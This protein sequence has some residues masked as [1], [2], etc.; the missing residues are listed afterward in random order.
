ME[1]VPS[2]RNYSR[3]FT[4]KLMAK[5]LD[6]AMASA[7]G[8]G[9]KC[10]MGSNALEIYRKL[11]EDGCELKDFS[12]A[13]QHYY[14]RKNEEWSWSYAAKFPPFEI[15]K[16]TNKVRTCLYPMNWNQYLESVFPCFII[17]LLSNWSKF[18]EPNMSL[19]ESLQYKL[20]SIVPETWWL[21]VDQWWWS[22][23]LFKTVIGLLLGNRVILFWDRFNHEPR[24]Y[25]HYDGGY[26]WGSTRVPVVLPM[27]E[28]E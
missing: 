8:V 18:L 24:C 19:L 3:G 27:T 22:D 15:N 9:F 26:I 23:H 10:P 11:C 4:S 28:T 5:D 14:S 21:F 12:C 25:V 2:S 1:G 6:L 20:C 17:R 7:S 13:F 16:T